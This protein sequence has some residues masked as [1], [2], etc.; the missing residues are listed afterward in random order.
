MNTTKYKESSRTI[1]SVNI[2]DNTISSRGGLTF[3]SHYLEKIK[4]FSLIDKKVTGFRANLKGKATSFII[5]QIILFFIDGSHKAMSGFDVLKKDEGYASVL[6]VS[7][8]DLLSS[9]A[10]KRFFKKFTYLKCGILRTILNT[11]F[12]WR[13]QI[14]RPSSLRVF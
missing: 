11:L 9:H 7:K 8:E 13:L 3:I 10:V 2:T 12:I 6:E 1:N 4:F 5:R 14:E